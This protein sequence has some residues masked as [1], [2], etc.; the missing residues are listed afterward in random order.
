[1]ENPYGQKVKVWFDK[2]GYFLE[3]TFEEK[4]GHMRPTDNDAVMER[5]D[6]KGKVI[7]FSILGVSK[8]RKKQPLVATLE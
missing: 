1:V 3:V 8:L 4:P 2:E 7:G 6:S 5:V